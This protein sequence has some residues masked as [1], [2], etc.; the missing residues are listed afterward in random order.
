MNPTKEQ[1]QRWYNHKSNKEMFIENESNEKEL[2]FDTTSNEDLEVD[3][4]I[5]ESNS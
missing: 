5:E 1:W 2:N 4:A 3:Q